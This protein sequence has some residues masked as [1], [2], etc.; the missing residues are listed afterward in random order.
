MSDVYETYKISD[1]QELRILHDESAESPREWDSITTMIC[2]HKRYT[3]GDKHSYRSEDFGSWDELREQIEEDYNVLLILPL[4]LHDHSGISMSI[5]NSSGWDS[6]QVGWIFIANDVEE[7]LAELFEDRLTEIIKADVEVYDQ[8]LQG[9]TYG[10]QLIEKV[11]CET[12]SHVEE[13]VVDSCWGFYGHDIR[14]NGI[15]DNL[16]KDVRETILSQ[17]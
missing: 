9:D 10:Y 17:V 1:S 12:C 15:L 11:P 13:R 4:M 14:K 5:G 3:L 16:D 6:G 8:Y 7:S 2:F